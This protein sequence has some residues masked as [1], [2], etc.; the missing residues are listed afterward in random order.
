M[1]RYG[2]DFDNRG[3][4]DFHYWDHY[5]APLPVRRY[6]GQYQRGKSGRYGGE[7]RG[8]PRQGFG[9]GYRGQG[10]GGGGFRDPGRYG[11]DFSDGRWGRGYYGQHG[12]T[13]RPPEHDFG[14]YNM[15]RGFR[16]LY[17]YRQYDRGWYT[18]W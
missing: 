4:A 16:N 11:R 2:Q 17:P 6:G 10:G 1:A 18:G 13:A 14:N 5:E 9:G 12:G 3:K 8:G 7:Y 15:D